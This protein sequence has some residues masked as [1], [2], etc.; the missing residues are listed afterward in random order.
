MSGTG[1]LQ[2]TDIYHHLGCKMIIPRRYVNHR[3]RF[4][5]LVKVRIPLP[6]FDIPDDTVDYLPHI[7]I[8]IALRPLRHVII[9]IISHT[10]SSMFLTLILIACR[11]VYLKHSSS[12]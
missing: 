10:V 3:S 9:I 12:P 2:I 5:A 8:W 7:L 4:P 11:C 6:A 1:N